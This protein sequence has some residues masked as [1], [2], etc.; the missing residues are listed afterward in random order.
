MIGVIGSLGFVS[1]LLVVLAVAAF[2]AWSYIGSARWGSR[3]APPAVFVALVLATLT[4]AAVTPALPIPAGWVLLF[5][6]A[7][8]TVAAVAVM[9]R[10]PRL[11]PRPSA[12][13]LALWVPATTGAVLWIAT[14]VAAEFVPG[15]SRLSWAM[16]GDATNNL[17]YVRRIVADNGIV[18]GATQNPV[19]LPVSA[20]ALPLSF[21]PVPADGA[22]P[23][24]LGSAL[25]GEFSAYGWIWVGVL[26]VSCVVMGVVAASFVDPSKHR[27]VAVASGL[28]SLL[29]LTW[30]VGGLP[31]AFGYFNMPFAVVLGLT[32]WLLFVASGRSPLVAL[33]ALVGVATLLLLT[34]TP[35]ALIPVTLGAVLAVRERRALF[36]ARGW[37]LAAVAA[38][39]LVGSVW[40]AALTVPT[41]FV[42]SVALAAPGQGYPQPWLFSLPVVG[43]VLVAAALARTRVA[44]PVFAGVVA[45]VAASYACVALF[46][47]L[48]RAVFDPWTAYYP[49]KVTWLVCV[50][51]L[52]IG[53]SL[54]AAL[55]SLARGNARAVAGVA[56]AGCLVVAAAAFPPVA[57]VPGFPPDQP[58]ARILSGQVWTTGDAAVDTIVAVVRANEGGGEVPV[59][60]H[61]GSADEQM[62]NFWTIYSLGE[63]FPGDRELRRFAFREYGPF[64]TAGERGPSSFNVL[65]E[66]L[67]DPDRSMLVYTDDPA[68]EADFDAR[69]TG[70]SA[71]YVVGATPGL[72]R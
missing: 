21:G 12:G 15:A 49:V 55:A 53:L 23:V 42:Q 59:L 62:V 34:W 48:S 54:V 51:L 20:V 50:V 38:A 14:R 65:C 18:L 27:S 32:S 71:R 24:P 7:V 28:G 72:D 16:E 10:M 11:R 70:S 13:A 43:V 69:C 60:W 30:F 1:I 67:R 5:E 25:A 47:F 31:I 35:I 19:P 2:G 26:A 46:L 41:Y 64:R 6:F 58:A 33:V 29:P 61:S 4:T 36:G 8:A 3:L 66:L 40:A 52:P 68:T 45:V 44:G 22:P 37:R 56:V 39:V 57:P 17:N 63:Q 9:V